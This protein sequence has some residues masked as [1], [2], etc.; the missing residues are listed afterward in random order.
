M[1]DWSH[2]YVNI[3]GLRIHFVRHGTGLPLVLLHGWPEFWFT[4]HRNIPALAER[5][6]VVV[7]DLRGFGDTEKPSMRPSI[8]T[9]AD[10]LLAFADAIGLQRF[11]LVGHDVGAT[12]MQAVA[13]RAPDRVVGL[14]FFNC[15]HPGIGRRWIERGHYRELWYQS[16]HQL[17][18]AADLVGSSREACRQYFSHF[19]R[20]WS[21]DDHTFD[22]DLEIW[23]DNFMKPGNLQ[24]GFNWY[25]AMDVLRRQM[26]LHGPLAVE[27]I[28][29]PSYVLWGRHDPI[30]LAEWSDNLGDSFR[31]VEIEI[32]E[33][34]GHFVHY[35]R[36]DLANARM[37]AFFGTLE[38]SLTTG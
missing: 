31:R 27:P 14:F 8:D 23:I 21:Y 24:G 30:L 17:A 25:A 26:I 38:E 34:A 28:R 35:E 36:P 33:E 11:G 32:A 16:F 7:P 20:H 22:A 4:W 18:W 10:D 29:P 9:Y 13:R 1:S 12:V 3:P 6:D 15:P 5:F 2:D 19:L 37:S